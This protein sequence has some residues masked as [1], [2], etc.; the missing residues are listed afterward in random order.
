MK[1]SIL[2]FLLDH[3]LKDQLEDEDIFNEWINSK[4]AKEKFTPLHFA[5]FKGDLKS[6]QI[7]VEFGANHKATNAFGLSMLHVATQGDAANTLYYFY[8]LGLDIN[9]QDYRGSTPLHWACFSQSEVALTFLVQWNPDMAIQDNQG[10]TPLH[11]A[12]KS[13]EHVQS[14]RSVRYL[15]VKNSPSDIPNDNGD[16]PVDLLRDVNSQEIQLELRD[17]L[18]RIK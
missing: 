10:Q 16:L 12:I 9:K 2:K 7:L 1:P 4:T 11:L 6:C 13:S 3:A 8:K 17:M 18:V 14:T 15:L 5:S